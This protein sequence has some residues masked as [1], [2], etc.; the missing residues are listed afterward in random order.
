[1]TAVLYSTGK[2]LGKVQVRPFAADCYARQTIGQWPEG[3]VEASDVMDADEIERI[4]IS[5]TTTVYVED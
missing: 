5:S 3:L 2:S 4:G 1:M